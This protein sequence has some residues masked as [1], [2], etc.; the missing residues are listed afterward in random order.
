MSKPT[1]APGRS[2]SVLLETFAS[3][4]VEERY[5]SSTVH[6]YVREAK[7]FVLRLARRGLALCEAHDAHVERYVRSLGRWRC[8]A[9]PDGQLPDSA[10]AVH[11]LLAI[12]RARGLVA[13]ASAP[14]ATE[15]EK[16]LAAFGD[17]L[18][19][20][21]GVTAGTRQVYLREARA[22]LEARF[23][24]AA[25]QW[26][27]LR[28]DDLS[29]FVLARVAR[30]TPSSCRT[31]V[32]ATRVLLR[33]LVASGELRDGLEA[34]IPTVRQWK[35]GSLPRFLPEE[36]VARVLDACDVSTAMGRRDRAILTLLLQ[37]GLRAGEVA[38]L[39]LDDI[40]W[41]TA[42][43]SVGATKSRRARL[44]PLP[45]DTGL[46]LAVYLRQARPESDDRAVFLCARAPHRPLRSSSVSSIVTRLLKCSGVPATRFG[47]HVLRHTAATRMIRGGATFKEVADILGHA[48]LETT[49]IYAK[50]DV[51][52]LARVALPWPGGAR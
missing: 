41:C 15:R 34:A 33:F 6:R 4:L 11:K 29:A 28:A 17:H 42:R 49:A 12:L 30:L 8:S 50:L 38:G 10:F 25:P 24:S 13:P 9:R 36:A 43:L 45:H 19:S 52:A 20:V 26:S 18:T 40:A 2:S 1:S 48:R 16:W 51:A 35:H 39:H 21:N 7:T 22:L 5:A 31:P 32:T 37:L 23:G 3:A 14:P 46:A 27:E 44:L 47:A